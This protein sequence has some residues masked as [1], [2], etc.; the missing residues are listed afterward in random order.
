MADDY[1]L[2]FP[3]W[4][5]R[6]LTSMVLR[7]RNHPSVIIWSIGNEISAD[8]NNYGPR[9]AALVRS[10]D[11]TRPVVARRHERR[12]RPSSDPW[13]YVDIGDYHG[14]PT[15]PPITPRIP[16]KAFL[17]SEDTCAG[18][19]RRLEARARQP[20]V[21]RQPGC[22]S[23]W[24]YIGEAGSGATVVAATEAEASAVGFG[25]VTGKVPYPWFNNFQC[26]IDLIGQRKPQNYWRAVVNGLSPLELMVERPTPPGTAAV[27]RLVRLLRRAAE[28]DVGRSAG[29][30][31]DRPRLHL[32]R[33]RHAAAQRQAGGDQDRSPTPTSA[34]PPSACPTRPG[35]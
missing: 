24:D 28:L 9:L 21:R 22:G 4:W 17:Q 33:Q 25:A 32:R 14:A 6:D 23:A 7:D 29:P 34:W 12:L 16:D 13:Q 5:E 8:P 30:A 27:R 1:H 31:D 18:D 20:V 26:D 3:D 2:Y 19:L 35:S 10:L 15:R 11:T